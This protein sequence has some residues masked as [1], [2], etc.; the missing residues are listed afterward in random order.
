MT[1]TTLTNAV[2]LCAWLGFGL[3]AWRRWAG[4]TLPGP[5]RLLVVS[6]VLLVLAIAL[7][8]GALWLGTPASRTYVMTAAIAVA[9]V[10]AVRAA[11]RRG[12]TLAAETDA[13]DGYTVRS[14]GQRVAA[15]QASSQPAQRQGY[16]SASPT[17]R[18]IE[19]MEVE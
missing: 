12:P 18:A 10:A 19:N 1:D 13:L 7:Q 11:G 2:M 16:A 17:V 9:V 14:A 3:L 4:I 15:A 8:T 5:R 6:S